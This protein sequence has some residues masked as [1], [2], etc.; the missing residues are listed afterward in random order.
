MLVLLDC[1]EEGVQVVFFLCRYY[2]NGSFKGGEGGGL[3]KTI[4]SRHAFTYTV[5]VPH[6]VTWKTGLSA[7][8]ITFSN[9]KKKNEPYSGVGILLGWGGGEY[10]SPFLADSAVEHTIKPAQY[11]FTF[12]FALN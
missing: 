6:T 9:K 5:C 7:E 4:S 3:T 11:H 8:I 12:H 10:M 1:V 2:R